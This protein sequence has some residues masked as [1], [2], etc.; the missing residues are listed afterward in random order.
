[1]EGYHHGPLRLAAA[2][3]PHHASAV[4][5]RLAAT[6]PR[7]RLERPVALLFSSDGV[8]A[9]DPRLESRLDGLRAGHAGPRLEAGGDPRR[10]RGHRPITEPLERLAGKAHT[11]GRSGLTR[12]EERR[13]ITL[14]G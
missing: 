6:S 3:R 5:R 2:F 4:A 8:V 11:L 13:P 10:L 14:T 12:T 7:R 1:Q 9:E